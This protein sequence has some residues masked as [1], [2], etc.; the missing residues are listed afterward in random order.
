MFVVLPPW[1]QARYP[2]VFAPMWVPGVAVA[3]MLLQR[4]VLDSRSKAQS[5]RPRLRRARRPFHPHPFPFVDPRA[6]AL[7]WWVRGFRFAW[8]WRFSAASPGPRARRSS[9]VMR[10]RS[11]SGRAAPAGSSPAVARTHR[12]DARGGRGGC[13]RGAVRG[14][15][16]CRSSSAWA[17]GRRASRSDR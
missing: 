12:L 4:F 10:S 17:E 6:R 5:R 16:R 8:F 11:G 2:F 13:F 14:F 9:S 15:L 3:A 1:I 7:R